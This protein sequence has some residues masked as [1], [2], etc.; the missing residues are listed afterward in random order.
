[1]GNNQTKSENNFELKSFD[2]GEVGGGK[3]VIFAHKLVENAHY[4][5]TLGQGPKNQQNAG[6][7]ASNQEA[8]QPKGK[9]LLNNFRSQF[10]VRKNTNDQTKTED[11]NAKNIKLRCFKLSETENKNY[12]V[13]EYTTP[14]GINYVAKIIGMVTDE[15]EMSK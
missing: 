7:T 6:S 12:K 1:M 5:V 14:E 2:L 15:P 4:V 9:S 3:Q 8:T 10:G 11:D 13:E